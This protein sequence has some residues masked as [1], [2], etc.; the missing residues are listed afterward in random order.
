MLQIGRAQLRSVLRIFKIILSGHHVAAEFLMT[1]VRLG[2]K[3]EIYEE[4]FNRGTH[5]LKTRFR[6]PWRFW[7][8][9]H[10]HLLDQGLYLVSKYDHNDPGFNKN[11]LNSEV[12]SRITCA[13]DFGLAHAPMQ[14]TISRGFFRRLPYLRYF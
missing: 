7:N 12:I 5:Y 4:K 14:Q 10:T 6:L 13:R 11:A 8:K 3:I 1:L 2:S 9:L